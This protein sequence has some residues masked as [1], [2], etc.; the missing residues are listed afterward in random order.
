MVYWY[1]GIESQ[2]TESSARCSVF[3]VRIIRHEVLPL[4]NQLKTD[5]ITK[6]KMLLTSLLGLFYLLS[7]F[8]SIAQPTT[9]YS[10]ITVDNGLSQNSVLTIA[11]D[12]LG[13]IWFG[14]HN[15]LNRFDGYDI[16]V[17]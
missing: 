13:F 15:G 16:K 14:T 11:Q 17:Y 4:T 2:I 9:N 7:G 3:T 12:E 6:L 5:K 10:T 1:I 8:S